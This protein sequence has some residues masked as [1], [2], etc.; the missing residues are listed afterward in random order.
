MQTYEINPIKY[1]G[2]F[3]KTV[4]GLIILSIVFIHTEACLAIVFTKYFGVF[5]QAKSFALFFFAMYSLFCFFVMPAGIG[6]FFF[7]EN[8]RE[9]GLRQVDS[10]KKAVFLILLSLLVLVPYVFFCAR[11]AEFQSYSLGQPS[12]VKFAIISCTFFPLY[13][14]AEE[15]FFRGFLF[16]SFWKR[17]KWHSFWITDIIFTLAHVGKPGLEILLC[18]PVSIILNFLTLTTK[19][20]FPAVIVHCILGTLLSFLISFKLLGV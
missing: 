11:R 4:P 15:F 9:M 3:F 6:R 8:L 20:I 2:Q 13:Y 10:R 14:F 12:A 18:I 19:S 16:I 7:R 5:D 1:M 17:V